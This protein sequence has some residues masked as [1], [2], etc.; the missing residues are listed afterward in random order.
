MLWYWK[1]FLAQCHNPYVIILQKTMFSFTFQETQW[2]WC[3][4]R[5]TGSH[6]TGTSIQNGQPNCEDPANKV[7]NYNSRE[8]KKCPSEEKDKFQDNLLKYLTYVMRR[9]TKSTVL[10]KDET[11]LKWHFQQLDSNKD[12]VRNYWFINKNKYSHF[13]TKQLYLLNLYSSFM[14][15]EINQL[16][17]IAQ[18][19]IIA[20]KDT[21][22]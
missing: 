13:I 3:V 21:F 6:I 20:I 8:W 17:A 12:G 9:V 19:S 5:L 11:T 7:S 15:Y 22:H 1:F 10:N 14:D 4:D 16:A 18:W 2:C